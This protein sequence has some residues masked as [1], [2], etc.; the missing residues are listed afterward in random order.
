MNLGAFKDYYLIGVKI[1]GDIYQMI[2]NDFRIA[3]L[4]E[5]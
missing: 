1:S 3:Q 2:K 4:K 5:Q